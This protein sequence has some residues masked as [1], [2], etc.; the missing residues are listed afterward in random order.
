MLFTISYHLHNLK[1]VKTPMEECFFPPWVFFMFFKLYKWYQIAQPISYIIISDFFVF[2]KSI[3]NLFYLNYFPK[4]EECNIKYIALLSTNR[5]SNIFLR[6]SDNNI[7]VD[8]CEF[9]CFFS[10]PGKP[11]QRVCERKVFLW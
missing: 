4:F 8:W 1:D 5:I 3:F 6:F 2:Q 7:Y 9:L 10:F 11:A